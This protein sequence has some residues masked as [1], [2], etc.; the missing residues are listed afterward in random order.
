MA[1][2]VRSITSPKK[3][4]SGQNLLSSL[5]DYIKDYGDKAFVICDEF[6]LE[7]AQKEAGASI[8][9]AGNQVV[10]E[11]FQ[12]E[13]TKEEIDRNRELVRKHGSNII[14][15]IGGEKH[16]I[17]L[18]QRLIMKSCLLLFSQ[19]LLLQMLLVPRLR[20]YTKR[21]LFR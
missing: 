17:P 13:C 8:E 12:Y 4:I 18:R 16:W 1:N 14:I 2:V 21:W 9:A 5:N 11:K 20:L 6:I 19:R 7:R 15:G 10:F 3:F